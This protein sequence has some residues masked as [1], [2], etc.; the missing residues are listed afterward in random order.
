MEGFFAPQDRELEGE[1]TQDCQRGPV[2]DRKIKSDDG[3]KKHSGST[4]M[5]HGISLN[6]LQ[7]SVPSDAKKAFGLNAEKVTSA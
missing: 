2:V 4:S 7:A 3:Y 6:I 5:K 1:Q